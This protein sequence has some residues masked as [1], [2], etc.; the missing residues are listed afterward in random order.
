[1]LGADDSGVAR[2]GGRE[3][4][5]VA[6]AHGPAGA[7]LGDHPAL[8]ESGRRR[9]RRQGPGD[10]EGDPRLLRLPFAKIGHG[11]GG[12]AEVAQIEP[13]IEKARRAA[14]GPWVAPGE[15]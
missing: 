4:A 7:T 11:V 13:P 15:I 10:V 3:A 14:G 6:A 12:G 5:A 2:Q 1:M 9:D 8:A